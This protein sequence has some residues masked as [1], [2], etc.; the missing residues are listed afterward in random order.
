LTKKKIVTLSVATLAPR[1]S[2][3]RVSTTAKRLFGRG[4]HAPSERHKVDFEKAMLLS[5]K[6]N[7]AVSVSVYNSV[8]KDLY[9]DL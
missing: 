1:A 4:E 8:C 3:V 9:R 7:V 5:I 6:N 2:A